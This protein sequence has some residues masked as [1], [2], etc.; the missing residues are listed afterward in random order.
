MFIFQI[1]AVG[2]AIQGMVTI[3]ASMYQ[4][5][6]SSINAQQA[7]QGAPVQIAM[8]PNSDLSDAIQVRV[9]SY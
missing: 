8:A 2:N 7:Q 9:H 4:T 3:P 5:V 6:V 1:L